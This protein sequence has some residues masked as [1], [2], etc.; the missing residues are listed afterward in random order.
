MNL[1]IHRRAS[2]LAFLIKNL[3][4]CF[5]Q[6][7]CEAILINP[8]IFTQE[9]KFRAAN[10]RIKIDPKSYYR[11]AELLTSLDL[12]QMDTNRRIAH[13]NNLRYTHHH[14]SG[15]IGIIAN[16]EGANLALGDLISQHGGAACGHIDLFGDSA[17]EDIQESFIMMEQ[18]KRVK[19]IL[20]NTFGGIFNIL[21]AV[22]IIITQREQKVT[23]KPIVLRIKG[24]YRDEAMELV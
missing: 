19:S 12:S 3:Y 22:K 9:R 8:L 7:D 21:D 4:E 11:Q 23:K 10:P 5:L 6:R 2:T 16:G 17:H 18:D 20:L 15:N 1:G 24:L 13:N 14:R